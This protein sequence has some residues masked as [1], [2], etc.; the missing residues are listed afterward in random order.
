MS[1]TPKF[2]KVK[3]GTDSGRRD[4]I[5]VSFGGPDIKHGVL[6]FSQ[7]D[8]TGGDT[9]MLLIARTLGIVDG[10]VRFGPLTPVSPYST[11]LVSLP[12]ETNSVELLEHRPLDDGFAVSV[13]NL[14]TMTTL[15]AATAPLPHPFAFESD[16]VQYDP[17]TGR[18]V[19]GG[20]PAG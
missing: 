1:H 2:Y 6:V 12:D 15:S 3:I 8:E 16:G 9:P 5:V 10:A 4:G 20:H 19:L 11:A 17:R 14:V 7:P 18:S 13:S